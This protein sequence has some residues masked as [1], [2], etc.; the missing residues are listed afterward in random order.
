[1]PDHILLRRILQ[2]L[3]ISAMSVSHGACDSLRERDEPT[4]TPASPPTRPLPTFGAPSLPVAGSNTGT[5][6]VIGSGVPISG[7]AGSAG[8]F[9][10]PIKPPPPVVQPS[11]CPSEAPQGAHDFLTALPQCQG[12][13]L[14]TH[15][16]ICVNDT[17]N[18]GC[19]A[20]RPVDECLL[21]LYSCGLSG[22]GDK[23][24]CGPFP[25]EPAICCYV[26]EGGCPV[27]RP[28]VVAG[29]ARLSTLAPGA[30]WCAPASPALE[31]LSPALR[32]VLAEAWRQDGSFEHASVASFSRFTL[33]LLAQG[34]PA[35]LV[36]GALRAARDEVQ[37]ARLCLGLAAAYAGAAQSPTSLRTD[38][39][40][41]TGTDAISIA[42]SL[43]SEGCIAETVSARLVAAAAERA[44][45]PCVRE[46]LETIARDEAEHVEL[47]WKALAWLMKRGDRELHS[48]VSGVFAHAHAHVGFGARVE[49]DL[50][51]AALA[52]HG[53]LSVPTRRTLAV[54]T[55]ESVVLPAARLLLSAADSTTVTASAASQA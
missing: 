45:D 17:A 37:H 6:G 7:V 16:V 47:A 1:M 30:Q 52:D 36:D 34:A 41:D 50:P 2:A 39:A 5:G 51:D 26:V 3:G 25:T 55:L 21:R 46:T 40:L 31:G 14:S 12:Q 44:T 23:V 9:G 4:E 43:A 10:V 29:V 15:E 27:G 38:D 32:A 8:S 22:R 20:D 33:Q 35:T 53:Y 49:H 28:F 54:R 19:D 18:R 42:V 13:M 48:A 24:L 11:S